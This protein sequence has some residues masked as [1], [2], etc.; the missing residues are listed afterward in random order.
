MLGRGV[1]LQG[2][3]DAQQQCSQHFLTQHVPRPVSVLCRAQP[4][5][6]QPSV[7]IHSPHRTNQPAHCNWAQHRQSSRCSAVKNVSTGHN[8]GNWFGNSTG[9]PAHQSS[10]STDRHRLIIPPLQVVALD[11]DEDFEQPTEAGEARSRARQL[12]AYMHFS[13]SSNSS[14]STRCPPC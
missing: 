4:A 14:S 12:P 10:S 5:W 2:S 7:D 11:R 3:V 13:S 8:S 9:S 6:P 1:R